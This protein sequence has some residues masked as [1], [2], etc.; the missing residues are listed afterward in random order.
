MCAP[1][2]SVPVLLRVDKVRVGGLGLGLGLGRIGVRVS[3][4]G[5]A[6]RHASP[7]YYQPSD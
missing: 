7:S 2:E 5:E 4:N 6:L 1:D 3:F